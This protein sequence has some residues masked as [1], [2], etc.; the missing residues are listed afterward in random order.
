MTS[1]NDHNT[2]RLQSHSTYQMP[3]PSEP[4]L[5]Q[6]R[7]HSANYCCNNSLTA[8]STHAANAD[9]SVPGRASSP[10]DT[11]ST[12][13]L[14]TQSLQVRMKSLNSCMDAS[15]ET[16]RHVLHIRR[17]FPQFLEQH[18]HLYATYLE[19]RTKLMNHA[20]QHRQLLYNQNFN[21]FTRGDNTNSHR[22]LPTAD[23]SAAATSQTTMTTNSTHNH[24]TTSSSNTHNHTTA[25]SSISYHTLVRTGRTTVGLTVPTPQ[26]SSTLHNSSDSTRYVSRSEHQHP[27]YPMPSYRHRQEQDYGLVS[28]SDEEN[29]NPST[30]DNHNKSSSP[31][32]SFADHGLSDSNNN[33]NHKYTGNPIAYSSLDLHKFRK[34][35]GGESIKSNQSYISEGNFSLPE[36][37][38]AGFMANK[39]DG[40]ETSTKRSEGG[41]SAFNYLLDICSSEVSCNSTKIKAG[42]W[43]N[44]FESEFPLPESLNRA[45]YSALRQYIPSVQTR[46]SPLKF[47]EASTPRANSSHNEYHYNRSHDD[48]DEDLHPPSRHYRKRLSWEN[49]KTESSDKLKHTASYSYNASG[50][51]KASIHSKSKFRRKTIRRRGPSFNLHNQEEKDTGSDASGSVNKSDSIKTLEV[52]KAVENI[53]DN[54][55]ST[56]SNMSSFVPSEDRWQPVRIMD[57]R[58]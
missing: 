9:D 6:N 45:R 56:A 5:L 39:M 33:N 8:T 46:T 23:T 36:L 53:F 42:E 44:A 30:E 10:T 14:D 18:P 49:D 37:T 16:R 4:S 54:P 7:G 35:D 27:R 52:I 50:S 19:E 58:A 31:K 40:G 24:T 28:R 22:R 25:N 21:L 20:I 12:I 3:F 11:Q 57:G 47:S 41:T 13:S 29:I 48:V 2:F 15:F 1:L 34:T 32:W 38:V 17:E 51:S 26:S 55:F 43:K